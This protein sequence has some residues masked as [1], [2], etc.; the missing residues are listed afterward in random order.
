MQSDS[1][2]EV[3]YGALAA[4]GATPLTDIM[5]V[6]HTGLDH[7]DSVIDIW[8]GIPMDQS[9]KVRWWVVPEEDLPEAEEDRIDW[10]FEH[11]SAIDAW[12]E[13]NKAHSA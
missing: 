6:T 2:R 10:L 1:I 7:L 12:I 3:H 13:A 4:V 9:L 8:R 5:F 11:W